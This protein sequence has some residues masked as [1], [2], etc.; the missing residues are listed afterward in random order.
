MSITT[1]RPINR[2]Q[3]LA[4]AASGLAFT[5]AP[6]RA[7]AGGT[8]KVWKDPNC[9]CCTG[10]VDHLRKSGF[11]VEVVETA[12]LQDVKRAKGVPAALASCHTADLDGY[13][14]EGHVPAHALARLLS[15]RPTI[16]GLAV[17]GMPVGSPGMEG[18]APETYEVI[19]FEGA[20]T[21]V[22]GRYRLSQPV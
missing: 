11:A 20:T 7:S 1:S 15:E 4:M 9:G 8:L 14:I 17:P 21:R 6:I 3:T 5:L 18:G 12:T 19:A 16:S 22:F 2:R 10:W 13:V